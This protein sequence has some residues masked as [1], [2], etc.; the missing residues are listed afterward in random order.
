MHRSKIEPSQTE[1]KPKSQILKPN[2]ETKALDSVRLFAS[3]V[4]VRF[5]FNLIEPNLYNS[6][7]SVQFLSPISSRRVQRA[8]CRP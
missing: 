7:G 2:A 3:L 8:N 6:L 1:P 4:C 5:G